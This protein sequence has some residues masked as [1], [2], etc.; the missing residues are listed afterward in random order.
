MHR[1][2][3]SGLAAAGAVGVLPLQARLVGAVDLAEI[4]QRIRALGVDLSRVL[5]DQPLPTTVDE[6]YRAYSALKAESKGGPV[7]PER[8]RKELALCELLFESVDA[9]KAR[10]DQ[11]PMQAPAPMNRKARRAA[12]AQARRK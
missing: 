11:E 4:E 1:S 5:G 12:A 3:H 8:L 10:V 9:A 2:E 7:D 6:L